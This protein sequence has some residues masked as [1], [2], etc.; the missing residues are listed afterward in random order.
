M[1]LDWKY[2]GETGKSMGA[3]IGKTLEKIYNTY[4]KISNIRW[5]KDPLWILNK[6]FFLHVY[7]IYIHIFE[8]VFQKLEIDL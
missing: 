4:F 8:K 3:I 7:P 6:I 1:I 5:L 2:L